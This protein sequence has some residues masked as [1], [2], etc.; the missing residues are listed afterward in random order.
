[1]HLCEIWWSYIFQQ[2]ST[3]R[4]A[5]YDPLQEGSLRIPPYVLP[6]RNNCTDESLI[7]RRTFIS[8]MT[9]KT[10]QIAVSLHP[11]RKQ[12]TKTLG[13]NIPYLKTATQVQGGYH[14]LN[15]RQRP[16]YS[17]PEPIKI[18]KTKGHLPHHQNQS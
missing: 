11:M 9:Q 3:E 8:S 13:C 7:V 1:M 18:E 17:I 14:Q 16:I 12:P 15:P 6:H 2:V 10:Q 4:L 5:T